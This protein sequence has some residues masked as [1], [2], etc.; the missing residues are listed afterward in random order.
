MLLFPRAQNIAFTFDL[1]SVPDADSAYLS[2][3]DSD[4]NYIATDS[5]LTIDDTATTLAEYA[6]PESRS[7]RVAA[8]TDII[9]GQVYT[10]GADAYEQTETARVVGIDT[11]G[12]VLRLGS[13]LFLPHRNGAAF[14]SS[15]VSITLA[16][17]LFPNP[18]RY[19]RARL[20]WLVD[21]ITTTLDIEFAVS[22]HVLDSGLTLRHV[23]Q[24]DPAVTKRL[25]DGTDVLGVMDDARLAMNA[26]I[27]A[28]FE[29]FL[30]R[31]TNA[32]YREA[33]LYRT[34]YMLAETDR[35][36]HAAIYLKQ[37]EAAL[38]LVAQLPTIDHDDDDAVSPEEAAAYSGYPYARA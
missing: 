20:R 8:V 38:T 15:R 35:P 2:L 21:T 3:V 26:D 1:P 6:D 24:R 22:E 5:V 32:A 23:R 10:V 19:G 28:R 18:I 14:A 33:H 36:T 4:G 34:L 25:D 7:V 13:P 12:K 27:R 17:A 31:G 37:Y 30:M 11:V 9:P 16:S 29:P